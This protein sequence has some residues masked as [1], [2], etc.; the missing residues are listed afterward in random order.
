[1]ARN[2]I[3]DL[4]NPVSRRVAERASWFG[5]AMNEASRAAQYFFQLNELIIEL[6]TAENCCERFRST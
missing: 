3:A 4:A 1:M 5:L 6:P 2:E